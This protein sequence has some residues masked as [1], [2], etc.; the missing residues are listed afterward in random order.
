MGQNY[1][2]PHADKMLQYA[3]DAQE[4][5]TPWERWEVK[6]EYTPRWYQCSSHPQWS[7]NREYRRKSDKIALPQIALPKP[8]NVDGPEMDIGTRDAT[9]SI[10]LKF[11]QEGDA[12]EWYQYLAKYI[13]FNNIK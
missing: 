5:D 3:Q 13:T 10:L 4:T 2:H 12:T 11:N 6:G 8:Y 9:I 1:K 7:V